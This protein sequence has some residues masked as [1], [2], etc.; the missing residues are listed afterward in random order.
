[1]FLGVNIS[2]DASAALLT[3]EGFVKMA[4]AEERFSRVKNHVGIPVNSVSSLLASGVDISEIVIGTFENPSIGDAKRMISNL[5]G[6]PSNPNGTWKSVFPGFEKSMKN[7]EGLSAKQIIEMEFEKIFLEFSANLPKVKWI[8]HHLSH[9][10]CSL[11]ITNAS[12]TLLIS[13]DGEGDGESG[14]IALAQ[15]GKMDVLSRFSRL[16]SLGNLYSAVTE[17]Y[18]FKSGKHE[19]K[20]TGLAAFG[21]R[22]AACEVLMDFVEVVDGIPHIRLVRD[23]KDRLSNKARKSLGLGS[24]SARSLDEIV[25]LAES[26]THNY[27]DLAYAIQNILEKSVIEIVNY[28]TKRTETRRLALAGGVF[29]NVKLNQKIAEIDGIES[30]R[31][32]PNMG[33]GGISIGGV[34]YRISS[35]IGLPDTDL[36]SN[37]YLSPDTKLQDSKLLDS[38]SSQNGVNV[39]QV[40]LSQIPK[41]CARDLSNGYIT[42]FHYGAMEFGPRAL[43]HRSL[44][45][46]PRDS[47]VIKDLNRRLSRTEF[48]P[49]API[50]SQ[51]DAHKYFV[52]PEDL[53]PFD[54]MTMTCNV[55]SHFRSALPAV[56]HID[57][58]ARPQ[59]VSKMS[60]EI[61]WRLLKEFETLTSIPILV[62][63]SLNIHE[64]PIN[65][66]LNDSIKALKKGAF[67][68]LYYENHRITY[69]E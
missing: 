54:Y 26:Q 48:M 23:F 47:N 63:T 50:V 58:T 43:G 67:D 35:T 69:Q 34:W 52:L 24:T 10:G 39:E 51:E 6:N 14:A 66:C 59:I 42:A 17:R 12:R 11:G 27:A 15:E 4:V 5:L 40:P 29:A 31:V 53:Q 1:M 8:N 28:W 19:G 22:S 16:D 20:I 30:V 21:N 61:L 36:I 13:L 41:R 33:D 32:F 38:L 37:M 3:P 68:I 44:L 49:F 46:D 45:A 18:N 25:S 56:T 65:Y 2:H 60:N 7:L 55:K 62:N 9:L 64:D 57:G